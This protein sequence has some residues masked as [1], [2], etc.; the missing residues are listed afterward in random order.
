AIVVVLFA[1]LV[2]L[3]P[4]AQAEALRK[5]AVVSFGLFGD[6]DVFRSESTGAAQIVARRFGGDPVIV[7]F[8]TKKGGG[9]TIEG[10]EASLQATAEKLNRERD[11]LFVILTSHGARNGLVVVRGRLRQLLPPWA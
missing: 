5:V 9:A 10:L 4:G 3:A 8:N 6:Q 1:I 11:I 7:Q 2:S